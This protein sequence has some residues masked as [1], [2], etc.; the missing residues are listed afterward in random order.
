MVG[1][2]HNSCF[3]RRY[4]SSFP[5]LPKI[6]SPV[7]GT[8][9]V[10]PSRIQLPAIDRSARYWGLTDPNDDKTCFLVSEKSAQLLIV[11]LADK[12]KT[13]FERIARFKWPVLSLMIVDSIWR[14]PPRY[15][16]A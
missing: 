4:G 3:K 7:N 6:T 1:P 8:L 15:N 12:G 5:R 16:R 10:G 14:I 2:T 11:R 13:E 9:S